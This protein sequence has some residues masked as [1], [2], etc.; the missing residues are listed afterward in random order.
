MLY[1]LTP[2]TFLCGVKGHCAKEGEPGDET[3]PEY[4][5]SESGI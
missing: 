3:S 2:S 4:I 1:S 5:V